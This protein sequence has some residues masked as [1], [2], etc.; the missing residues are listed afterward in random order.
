MLQSIISRAPGGFIHS[1][2][3]LRGPLPALGPVA[4]D[5]GVVRARPNCHLFHQLELPFC[6]CREPV[7]RHHDWNPVLPR[8]LNL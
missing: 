6:I 7:H 8:I 5:D 1:G 2:G 3:Q 4:A